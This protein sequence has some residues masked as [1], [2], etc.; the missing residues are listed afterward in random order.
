VGL[1]GAAPAGAT[2]RPLAHTSLE[3]RGAGDIRDQPQFSTPRSIVLFFSAYL[4]NNTLHELSHALTAYVL[5]VPSTLYPFY[6]DVERVHASA[7]QQAW[8]GAAGPLCSL[9]VG[10]AC[11]LVYTRARTTSRALPFLYLATFGVSMFLGNLFSAS[12]VGDFSRAA[13]ALNL[14]MAGRYGVTAAGALLLIA[15]MFVVGKE[16]LHWAPPQASA[17]RAVVALVVSP[18]VVGTGCVLVAYLPMPAW[19]IVG[20]GMASLFWIFA[21]VGVFTNAWRP[22]GGGQR[23]SIRWPDAALALV[24]LAVVRGLR[25]GVPLVP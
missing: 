18:V 11:W 7:A 14:P 6:V 16:L 19:Y 25:L 20:L 22:R 21:A 9:I 15:V 17:M 23:D 10:A 12:F 3:P 24:A 1:P 4:I 5:G 2:S 8:I 13:T